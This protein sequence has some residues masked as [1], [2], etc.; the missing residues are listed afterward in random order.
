MGIA[1]ILHCIWQVF[2]HVVVILSYPPTYVDVVVESKMVS[3]EMTV[4]FT[5]QPPIDVERTDGARVVCRIE[6]IP[7][8]QLT[9]IATTQPPT[10][11]YRFR[12]VLLGIKIHLKHDFWP[13]SRRP[14]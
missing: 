2:T 14:Q 1:S 7:S 13:T 9:A 3:V 4:A 11:L 12:M 5:G 10:T 8:H 6:P